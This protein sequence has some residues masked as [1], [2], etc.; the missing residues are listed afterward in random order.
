M[1][2]VRDDD[3]AVALARAVGER[4]AKPAVGVP[5]DALHARLETNRTE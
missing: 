1:V 3:G 2:P 4:D 5:L